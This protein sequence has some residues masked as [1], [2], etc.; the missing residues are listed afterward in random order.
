MR[1]EKN[2]CKRFPMLWLYNNTLFL[3]Y[4]YN[5]VEK[6]K[7]DNEQQKSNPN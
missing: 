6:I 4:I 2:K 3:I 7:M 1:S 5:Y